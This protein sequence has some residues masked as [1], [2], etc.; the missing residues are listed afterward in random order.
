MKWQRSV[1]VMGIVCMVMLLAG[2][3]QRSEQPAPPEQ[4]GPP[5]V[6]PAVTTPGL[7]LP[8]YAPAV[9]LEPTIRY[10]PLDAPEGCSTAVLV[11]GLPLLHTRQ[12]L[13][14]DSEGKLVGADSAEKQV[15]QVLENLKVVLEAGGSGLEKLVRVGVYADSPATV[16][17][18]RKQLAAMT[19][20]NARPALSAVIT[21]LPMEG[22]VVAVDAVAVSD[23]ESAAVQRQRCEAVAGDDSCAD[24]AVLP[25]GTVVYV[26]GQP[27]KQPIEKAAGDSLGKLFQTLELLQADRSQVVQLKVFLQP[28]A[29]ADQ[30]LRQIKEAF[31]GEL[32]PRAGP[33][34]HPAR[35]EAVAYVQSGGSSASPEADLRF[36]S[37]CPICRRRNRPGARS[38]R[39]IA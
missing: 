7:S 28:A 11:Q 24:W 12:L 9:D 1:V 3:P 5:A 14:L 27:S 16:D 8:E 17:L 13:P 38:V 36:R 2:C 19:D 26:S 23:K 37:P 21:P 20:E 15:L 33:V 34:L 18:V 30:V 22:A 6:S 25:V 31:A 4:L 39:A 32:V 10:F 29:A 35:S